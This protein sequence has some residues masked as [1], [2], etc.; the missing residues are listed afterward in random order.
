MFTQ[1]TASALRPA[2]GSTPW[3]PVHRPRRLQD[4]Q[5]QPRPRGGRRAAQSASPSA[6]ARRCR[7]T[8]CPPASAATSSPC[9]WGGRRPRPARSALA[10]SGS[11][12]CAGR[13]A[14]QGRE[15][16][17]TASIGIAARRRRG[18]DAE[19]VLRNADMAMY[20]AKERGKDRSSCSRSRCTPARSSAS[21]SRPTWHAASRPASSA[22]YQ[23]IVSLQT[24]RITGVE[25]LVR[26]DHPTRGRTL[27]R[28]VHPARRGHRAH[29]AARPVGARGGVPAA[30]A[31][32]LRLPRPTCR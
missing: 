14:I 9:W 32:Q 10:A 26:W 8:T 22:A 31:W 19:V 16:V 23:P 2:A 30:R 27:A 3:V 20:L 13:S 1:Q 25:A 4:G 7:P 18:H 29:R 15:I 11:T 21:S 24:G 5:R 12:T 17:V 6:C 28:R